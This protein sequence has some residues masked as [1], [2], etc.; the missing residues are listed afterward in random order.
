LSLSPPQASIGVLSALYRLWRDQDQRCAYS[1]NVIA[2][3]QIFSADCEI[4]HILPFKKSLDDSYMNKVL[5]FEKENRNKA[6]R[7]PIDAWGGDNDKWNQITQAISQWKFLKSKVDRFYMTEKDLKER[8]F[9]FSQLTD[10]RYISRL[11]QEYLRQLGCDV[12]VTKAQYFIH[13]TVIKRFFKW[14]YM[15]N[16]TVS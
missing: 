5:C 11:A 13:I 2:L 16:F 7:T 4:D 12:N 14:Q 1:G 8:Y 3:G 6:D 15:I 9:I 10:T